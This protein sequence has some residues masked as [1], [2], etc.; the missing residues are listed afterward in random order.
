M[1]LYPTLAGN[2][3]YQKNKKNG[4]NVPVPID[5][6]TLWV[7]YECN[8]CIE[9]RE[10]KANDWRIRLLE[11]I[12]HNK[13]GVFVTLTFNSERTINYIVK[14]IHKTDANHKYY[15][16]KVLTSSGIGKGYMARTDKERNKENVS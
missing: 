14:Y 12:R 4:G 1:C 2:K 10:R 16:P 15:K 5:G 11:D 8:N 3:K 6:R 7:V 13:N 9:C